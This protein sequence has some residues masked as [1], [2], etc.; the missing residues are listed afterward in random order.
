[1]KGGGMRER[2][3]L[4]A[5]VCET[6]DDDAP[7]LVFADWCEEHGEPERAEFIRLQL[8][9]AA[10][11]EDDP[12]RPPLSGRA[13]DLWDEHGE[14]W[15]AEI[16]KW[17]RVKTEAFFQRGFLDRVTATGPA[18]VKHGAAIVRH[19]PLRKL[20]FE[21]LTA[22]QCPKVAA[23]QALAQVRELSLYNHKIGNK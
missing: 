11:D 15:Q 4:L 13:G 1:M 6:P 3:A 9:K 17:S 10:M 2:E 12:E 18:F 7:R 19:I 21:K 20:Y 14:K 23:V 5:A 22:A 16:P 8:R